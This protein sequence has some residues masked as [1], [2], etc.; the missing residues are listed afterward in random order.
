M[1]TFSEHV[2]PPIL[3][4]TD[5]CFLFTTSWHHFH[6]SLGVLYIPLNQLPKVQ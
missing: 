5:I 3:F 6:L 1:F 2:R 4:P